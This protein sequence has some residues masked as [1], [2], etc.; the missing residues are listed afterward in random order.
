MGLNRK[1]RIRSMYTRGYSY[2]KS[3]FQ[4]NAVD[5]LF[6]PCVELISCSLKKIQLD[7]YCSQ[8]SSEGVMIKCNKQ[9][10]K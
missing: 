6:N 7:P 5:K 9:T 8:K 2:D 4:I 1:S 10:H 3:T